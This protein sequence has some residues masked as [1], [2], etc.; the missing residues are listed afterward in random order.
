MA[1]QGNDEALYPIAV[2]MCVSRIATH[3]VLRRQHR[4]MAS[5]LRETARAAPGPRRMWFRDL[6]I[7]FL[8]RAVRD[9]SVFAPVPAGTVARQCV[10]QAIALARD[11]L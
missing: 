7:V 9:C 11:Q 4:S 1:T 3:A 5:R 8:F 2:L 6:N 10:P